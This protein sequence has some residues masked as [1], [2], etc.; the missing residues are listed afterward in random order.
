MVSKNLISFLCRNSCLSSRVFEA[1]S[2]LLNMEAKQMLPLIQIFPFFFCHENRLSEI[3]FSKSYCMQYNNNQ[4]QT[5]LISSEEKV[6]FS[7]F[8]I[9]WEATYKKCANLEENLRF[10][11]W[12]I[13]RLMTL[14]HWFNNI[15]FNVFLFHEIVNSS[16]FVTPAK[17]KAVWARLVGVTRVLCRF[18][19]KFAPLAHVFRCATCKQG[20]ER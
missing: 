7:R 2:L 6:K 17:N 18:T 1:R 4:G 9:H 14:F 5:H 20:W 12:T 15:N 8:G 11:Y 10:F 13:C 19:S 16:Y 3:Y